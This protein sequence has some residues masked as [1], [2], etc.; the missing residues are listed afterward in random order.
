MISK[1][2]SVWTLFNETNFIIQADNI[3]DGVST[4]TNLSENGG[5]ANVPQIAIDN[6]TGNAISVWTFNNGGEDNKIQ[7]SYYNKSS[8]SW[9]TPIDI[10]PSANSPTVS[11]DSNGD[12]ICVWDSGVILTS[13]YDKSSN[14]WSTP[15]QLS[16][17]GGIAENAGIAIDNTTG[18]AICVWYRFNGEGVRVIQASYY[19]KSR[20]TWSAPKNLSSDTNSAIGP[21]IAIDNKTGNAICIWEYIDNVNYKN[22]IQV[23]Y[24]T[25][26]RNTWS[27]PKNISPVGE[28]STEPQIAI[29]N[30][31]G[32]AMSVWINSS[33]TFNK[34]NTKEFGVGI[35]M[36][37]LYNKSKNTWS[38]P[39]NLSLIGGYYSQPQI[40]I[41]N[42]TG[43]AISVWVSSSLLRASSNSGNN[44]IQASYYTKSKNTWSTPK[45]IS[46]VGESCQEPQIAIDNTTGDAMSVWFC[47]NEINYISKASYY[48][49]SSNS[50]SVPINLSANGT[51][52]AYTK[53]AVYNSPE[54]LTT[55]TTSPPKNKTTVKFSI[56]ANYYDLIIDSETLATY[57]NALIDAIVSLVG[58]PR[59]SITIISVTPGSIVNE[60]SL[61]TE[62]VAILKYLVQNGLFYITINGIRY[63]AIASSFVIV[64]NICF[65]KGTN[66]LTP[67]GYKQIESLT[68]GDL[69]TTAQGRVVKIQRVTNFTG[70]QEKCPLYVLQKDTLGANMPLMDLYMSAGHAYRH[71]GRWCHM[72]CSSL[73][74][75]VDLD[76]IEYYN[77]ALDKYLENTLVAN[78]VEVESLFNMKGLEM[79]WNCKTDNCTPIVQIQK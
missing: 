49:R 72:K 36:G 5:D 20:N 52:T 39:M 63:Y 24:Y 42:K 8:N 35:V 73:A 25:K 58:A 14:S 67:S 47:Y 16:L 37:S 53:I 51:N 11:M 69:V 13:R 34:G 31:T 76:N 74:M 48:T 59:D 66:I 4:I 9:S 50:W 41:D 23:S 46:V 2:I 77:I 40:A 60:L 15:R 17:S 45:N 22:V 61:P 30:T 68:R 10:S 27:T 62:Y 65:R 43:N 19:T 55:T 79:T 32:D 56:N 21:Q 28:D 38:E 26:G 29:D 75:E 78:G 1:A 7:S 33:N 57:E 70:S 12:A 6:S 54:P 18:N 71:N 44:I 3:V 64:D